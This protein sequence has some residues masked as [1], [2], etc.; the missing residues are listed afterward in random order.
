MY[1]RTIIRTACSLIIALLVG[2]GLHAGGFDSAET[3]PF[4]EPAPAAPS[5]AL[6]QPESS[7]DIVP[8]GPGKASSL[9][10]YTIPLKARQILKAIQDRQGDPPPGYVGGR[11]FQN[12]EQRLPR[13]QYREYDVNPRIRGKNRGAERIVIEQRTG[14]AY[15]TADHYR[16]FVPLN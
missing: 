12:R 6:L 15:Y 3:A 4:M 5:D 8:E 16:T 14:E 7:S 2:A 10:R 1:H 13:G 11:T 9:G